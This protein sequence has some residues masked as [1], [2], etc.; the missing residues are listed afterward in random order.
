MKTLFVLVLVLAFSTAGLYSQEPGQ[1]PPPSEVPGPDQAEI[2][3]PAKPPREV[4]KPQS[5]EE[6]DAWIAIE[7]AATLDEKGQLAESFLTRFPESGLTPYAHQLLALRYQEE[8]NYEKFVLHA[9]K[10]LEDL[11]GNFLI[12]ST[13]AAAYAQKDQSD[14]AIDRAERSLAALVSAQRPPMLSE[15][16][17]MVQREQISADAHYALGSA[18]VSRHQKAPAAKGTDDAN[19]KKAVEELQQAT[20]LDPTHDR[21]YYHLGFA[22]ARQDDAE[23]ALEAYARAVAIGGVARQLAREQL[24]KVYQFVYQNTDGLEQVVE[25]QKQYVQ[26]Q[27]AARQAKVDS[28]TPSPSLESPAQPP[29]GPTQPE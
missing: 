20:T 15:A 19:L 26:A 8:N 1:P 11:P 16:E 23:K 7:R 12:L 24:E 3:P 18:Y 21:A 29:P 10:T 25:Q 27:L 28:L 14:K 4:G 5:Q 6:L 9:E 13:L 2:P 22:F 17:W